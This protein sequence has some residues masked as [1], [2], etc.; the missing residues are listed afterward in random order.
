MDEALNG[1]DS[2]LFCRDAGSIRGRSIF[3][4]GL[5]LYFSQKPGYL[6]K[7]ELHIQCRAEMCKQIYL[8]V[9]VTELPFLLAR[10]WH[11][12]GILAYGTQS[13]NTNSELTC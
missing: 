13:S 5:F 1:P 4:F 2:N 8:H 11:L 3:F 12:I 10:I 6:F 7:K 9:F